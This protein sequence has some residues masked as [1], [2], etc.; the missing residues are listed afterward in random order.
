MK[1]PSTTASDF[2]SWRGRST[3]RLGALGI[4]LTLLIALLTSMLW[5]AEDA[6]AAVVHSTEARSFGT[7]GTSATSM[8]V[9]GWMAYHN[10][11]HRLY[12]IRV[13]N[14]FGGGT[15]PIYAFDNSTTG[16][17]TPV[18]GN[19]PLT[20][21]STFGE[22]TIAVDNSPAASNGNL[23]HIQF[24]FKQEGF[25]SA[26][27]PL[28]GWPISVVGTGAGGVDS[29]GHPWIDEY[30]NE[31]FGQYSVAGTQ[32]NSV[33][34]AGPPL[35]GFGDHYMAI[36]TSTDD[37]YVSASEIASEG[38]GI[39]K[40]TGASHYNEYKKILDVD[41]PQSDRVYGMSVNASDGVLYVGRTGRVEAYD[42]ST[43][44]LIE[45]IP[46]SGAAIGVVADET[47]GTL[48]IAS[49]DKIREFPAIVIPDVTAGPKISVG[50]TTAKVGGKVGRAGGA[51]VT[52]CY[53]EY[54]EEAGNYTSGPV[55]CE[56]AASPGSPYEEATTDVT[57]EFSGL[58]PNTTYHYRL[59]AK[60]E[61]GTNK[62][63]DATVT[64][65]TVIVDTGEAEPA[66]S[67]SVLHGTVNP[68]GLPTT[69]YFEYGRTAS[70]GRTTSTPPGDPVGTEEAGDQPVSATATELLPN[71]TYHYRLVGT[72]SNGTSKG[73]DRTFTTLQPPTVLGATTE[74]LLAT[75]VD[76]V[77]RI[78]PRGFATTYRFE[79]GKT[80][81]Y[82]SL[83]P[84]PDGSV[85]S[86]TTTE[87]VVVHLE[88]LEEAEYHFRVVAESKWGQSSSEDQTFTFNPPA[89]PNAAVRQQTGASYLPDCRAY[90]LVSSEN[91]G[92]ARL[93]AEGPWT[94][95][96]SNPGRFSYMGLFNA[97]PGTGDPQNNT[98]DMY[99][100]SRGDDGWTSHYVGIPA[101]ENIQNTG[102]PD[103]AGRAT[104]FVNRGLTKVLSWSGSTAALSGNLIESYAPYAWNSDGSSL[105]RLP[106]NL[107]SVPGSMDYVSDGG[108]VGASRP[109]EDFSHYAF[110]SRNLAFG[111]GGLTSAPGSVYD[112]DIAAE[113]VSVVSKTPAGGD[114]PQ[115]SGGSSEYV[116]IPAVSRDGSHIL[117]S[118]EAPG[119]LTHLYIRVGG[120]A[121]VSYDVSRGLDELNHGVK[122]A[123]MTADG[124]TVYFTSAEKLTA[125]DTDTS[126][127]LF[128]W[129]EEGDS[130]TKVSAG[131]PANGDTDSCTA[132]WISKC[133]IEVVPPYIRGAGGVLEQQTPIDSP[134]AAD[135]GDIY[136]YSPEQ[137]D[138][139]AGVRDRRNLY[140]FHDGEVQFVASLGGGTGAIRINVSD[141][142]HYAAFLT[143]T[144][145]LTSYETEG[146]PAM[147][148]YNAE[149]GTL[150]C[151][152]QNPSG[153]PPTSPIEGSLNGRFMTDDG[154]VFFSTRGALVPRD[155]D[156]IIDVYEYVDGR[157]QLIST[158]IGENNGAADQIVGLAGVSADG[159]DA[160]FSTYETLVG[161]DRNGPFYKFYDART[162]GGFR[163]IP[164]QAP[165]AAADEC[166]G[167]GSSSP[168]APQFGTVADLGSGG[169]AHS[170]KNTKKKHK[171]KR[172]KRKHRKHR[173]SHGNK[174]G[175][176]HG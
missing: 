157:P 89:C 29:T 25:T 86:G 121:G 85:G 132:S 47:S 37:W 102:P 54:G 145:G 104:M 73:E 2:D 41:P 87:Q 21:G 146:F 79:Y 44:E 23:Y 141:D 155:A 91:G 172:K 43:N 36:D 66:V 153:D 59:V 57:A 1:A 31:A 143:S 96:A 151:V 128:M 114:I 162:G 39:Y 137:L 129:S 106:T 133:G 18:G 69:F 156:G 150:V 147:Y 22:T 6:S 116:K 35:E 71:T 8:S 92:G 77:A 100:A 70:Y 135:A 130:V 168:A 34:K 158:G 24:E 42:T 109:S 15:G 17:T 97:I 98:G 126:T 154:R 107:G 5:K 9:P 67:D 81:E 62:S 82:G 88:G 144:Q 51:P 19:F 45:T 103:V 99:V 95:Y 27:T 26:G 49:G 118:T 117:M 58:T 84:E 164:P 46:V 63:A 40:F 30:F 80:P 171:S 105:G 101:T 65:L 56:P 7:D 93:T 176:R 152:S 76:L 122:F 138:G 159:T 16:V 136:F 90:E 50:H 110:S 160:F 20:V 83:A 174:G 170:S 173:G 28:S 68:D 149:T 127:D 139:E 33:S 94:P 142:G 134:M 148:R 115:D 123:G 163:F 167:P 60:N 4:A 169:N 124:E 75:S 131:D 48:F 72:N 120:A 61:N 74:H 52:E 32:L 125:D 78:N 10:Q 11:S 119:G 175:L 38:E 13:E 12:V 161:Q 165:C 14:A 64:P 53:F 3:A 166:H 112:N 140:A 111:E 55:P 113:T 108:Y